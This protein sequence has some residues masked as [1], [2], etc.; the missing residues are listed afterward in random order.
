MLADK[1][2]S[3]GCYAMPITS[4]QPLQSIQEG[5]SHETLLLSRR[6]LAL[7]H[8][9]LRKAGLPIELVKTDIRAKKLSDGSDDFKVNP[10]GYVPALGL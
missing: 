5:A 4:S 2:A 7:P 6:L 1:L 3:C 8:I 10:K 9:A